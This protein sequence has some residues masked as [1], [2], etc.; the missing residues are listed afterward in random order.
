MG[1]ITSELATNNAD[2]ISFCQLNLVMCKS[3]P[4]GTGFEGMDKLWRAS[5]TFHYECLGESTVECVASVEV[6]APG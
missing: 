1:S 4:G 2:S 6:E 5:E 3:L